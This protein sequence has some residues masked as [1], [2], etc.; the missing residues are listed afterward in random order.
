[1]KLIIDFENSS[2][3][4]RLLNNPLVQKWVANL[5]VDQ[6]WH[7]WRKRQ[8]EI[9]VGD[10]D[11]YRKDLINAIVEFNKTVGFNFPFVVDN[12][13]QFSREDL[14]TIHRYFT[15]ITTFMSWSLGGEQ[16][17]NKD[18]L[19]FVTSHV[20]KINDAVHYLENYYDTPSKQQSKNVDILCVA[21]TSH[22]SDDYFQHNPGDWR[23]LDYDLEYDVFMSYAICGKD[24]FQ[25]YIDND[26][27]RLWDITSQFSSYYNF[28]YIDIDGERNKVMKSP[29]FTQWLK[30]ANMVYNTAWQFMPIG[31]VI[32]GKL[33][34]R[35]T[36]KGIRLE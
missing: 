28:F 29:E 23:Y 12:N 17:I 18:Q 8:C 25:A 34:P 2:I 14:N 5:N 22:N 11:Q 10:K 19:G 7:C 15:T 30:D 26:D 1:M 6:P 36:F 16:I 27:P 21:P 32:S 4:I 31:K 9:H 20:C 33:G 24:Y 35:L 13:T 3:T